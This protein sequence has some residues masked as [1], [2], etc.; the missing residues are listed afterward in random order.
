MISSLLVS[1]EPIYI[2]HYNSLFEQLWDNSI[3]AMDRCLSYLL[4][5]V[6]MPEAVA[7]VVVVTVAD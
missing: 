5:E 4:M 3:D 2:D 7:A 6:K 1:N